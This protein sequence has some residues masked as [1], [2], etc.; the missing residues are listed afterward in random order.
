MENNEIKYE[1]YEEVEGEEYE[2]VEG[3]D[4]IGKKN[5]EEE[6]EDSE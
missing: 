2:E 6:C 5:E 4:T 1:E 3:E